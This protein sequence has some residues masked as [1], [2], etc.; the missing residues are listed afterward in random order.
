M[1]DFLD[2]FYPELTLET[3]DII[4]TIAVKKDYSKI[5]DLDERKEEFIKD[6]KEFIKEFEETPESDDFMRYYDDL[7]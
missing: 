6:L 5:E 4:M 1:D 3:D 7:H 2:E